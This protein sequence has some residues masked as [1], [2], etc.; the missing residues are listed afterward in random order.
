MNTPTRAQWSTALTLPTDSVLRQFAR[1]DR[2]GTI[3][4]GKF[5]Y[6][7]GS[8]AAEERVLMVAHADTVWDHRTTERKLEWKG[9]AVMGRGSGCGA[10]DR[11]GCMAAWQVAQ[12]G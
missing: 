5:V 3:A 10:D 6:L 7:P 4:T 2:P 12:A 11:A 9:R 8:R 1:L